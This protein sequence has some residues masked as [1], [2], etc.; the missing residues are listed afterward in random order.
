[1]VNLL[2]KDE[3]YSIL[4]EWNLWGEFKV[5]IVDRPKYMDFLNRWR[6]D[7]LPIVIYGLRRSGKSYLLF[8]EIKNLIR[9]EGVEEDDILYVNFED[10]RLKNENNVRILDQIVDTFI[11][12]RQKQ[13]KFIMLDE[14]QNIEGWENWVLSKHNKYKIYINGSSSKM[15]SKE[16]ST[17]LSGR[18]VKLKVHPLD[19]N[20]FLS[21]NKLEVKKQRDLIEKKYRIKHLFREYLE[22]GGFPKISF[23]GDRIAKKELLMS[24]LDSIVYKDIA[25]RYKIRNIGKFKDFLYYVFSNNTLNTNV[26]RLSKA[27][28]LSYQTAE[29]Y[30]NYL[31]ESFVIYELKNYDYSLKKQYNTDFKLYVADVGLYTIFSFRFSENIGRYLEN[32]VFLE[33][34]RRF[35][36]VYF[37]RKNR[38][39]DFIIGDKEKI[40]SA[41]QVTY[42]LNPHN[43]EREIGGLVEAMDHFGLKKGL[44]LTYDQEDEIRVK[45]KK[46][47]VKPVWKWLLES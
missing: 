46:I 45:G 37:F 35:S 31:K 22:F 30:L 32:I 33:L 7:N 36:E 3:L 44:L 9:E 42:H 20:E 17:S 10:Y 18:Y 39:C 11:Q 6:R 13:P 14:V 24:Y 16:I 1:M 15:L 47:I 38:E 23:V 8:Q 26:N 43:R 41:I 28:K 27:N 29:E 19:F 34:V 40:T 4:Y 25:E 2:S 12:F 21:F 5:D